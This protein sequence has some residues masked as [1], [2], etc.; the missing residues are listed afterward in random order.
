MCPCRESEELYLES[1][2]RELQFWQNCDGGERNAGL[3]SNVLTCALE[4]EEEVEKSNRG[5]RWQSKEAALLPTER[6]FQV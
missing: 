2:S 5:S 3:E 1:G 6:W 4:A